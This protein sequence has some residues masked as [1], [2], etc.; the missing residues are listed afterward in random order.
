LR[1]RL[2]SRTLDFESKNK[3]AS[4]FFA[5]IIKPIKISFFNPYFN[6]Q[7]NEMLPKVEQNLYTLLIKKKKNRKKLISIFTFLNSFKIALLSHQF[8]F[9]TFSSQYIINL[10]IL[11]RKHHLIENYYAIPSLIKFCSSLYFFSSLLIIYLKIS[12]SLISLINQIFVISCPSR[13]V[14]ITYKNLNRL[15]RSKI[16]QAQIYYILNTKYGLK[17]QF[18]ALRLKSGGNLLCKIS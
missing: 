14:Y 1:N 17:T 3:G 7:Q 15:Y 5:K 16:K 10:L 12:V 6:N 9:F 18:D 13:Y 4:P 11:L 8:F 2:I